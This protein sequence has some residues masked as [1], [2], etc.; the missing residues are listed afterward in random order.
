MTNRPDDP[1][2]PYE[3]R[4]ARRVG[5][6]AEQAVRP[7]DATAIASLAAAG[8]RRRTLAGRL[9]GSTS[10]TARLGVVLA[11]AIVGAAVLGVIGAGGLNGPDP[12]PTTAANGPEATPTSVPGAVDA[13]AP[14][15]L[16]AEITAWDGAAGHRIATVRVTNT[17]TLPC[18]VPRYFRP[19]LVDEDGHA[20]IVS[21]SMPEVAPLTLGAGTKATTLVDMA[22]YCGTPPTAPL[23]LRLYLASDR[24]VEA[25]PGG[26][27]SGPIDP[28]PCN[29]PNAPAEIQIQELQLTA[30]GQ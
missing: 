10:S 13:C 7:I 14:A 25:K 21:P 12:T 5:A 30:A 27:V 24:A 1:I 11:G 28:P 4:L 8:A 19:A 22:N 29:G 26:S 23:L 20:L 3:Q 16:G 17:G 18:T 2:D 6:F 9:F 15:G